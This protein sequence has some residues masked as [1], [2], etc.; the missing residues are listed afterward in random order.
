MVA[1]MKPWGRWHAN[2]VYAAGGVPLVARELKKAGPLPSM[3][4]RVTG[5]TRGEHA[6]GAVE[7]EGQ[8][9]ILPIETRLKAR[10]GVAVLYGNLAPE[11]CAVKLAGHDRTVHRGP[12]RVFDSEEECFAAVK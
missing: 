4:R 3:A 6:D 9:V 12:A 11:G 8:T 1:D 10:G 5:K 2:D 7:T